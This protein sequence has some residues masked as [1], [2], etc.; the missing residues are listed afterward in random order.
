[1]TS[2]RDRKPAPSV[3]GDRAFENAC[4]GTIS[5]GFTRIVAASD[6]N[7]GASAH[8]AANNETPNTQA[9]IFSIEARD[10]TETPREATITSQHQKVPSASRDEAISAQDSNITQPKNTTPSPKAQSLAKGSE[11]KSEKL[12]GTR[13]GEVQPPIGIKEAIEPQMISSLT[14][15]HSSNHTSTEQIK[16]SQA[17][18]QI[19]VVSL[20]GSSHN[21]HQ[22]LSPSANSGQ[23]RS[24]SIKAVALSS[25]ESSNTSVKSQRMPQGHNPQAASQLLPES[26]VAIQDEAL[27]LT[28]TSQNR[29]RPPI[30]TSQ[31]ARQPPRVFD[32]GG[33]Q[34]NEAPAGSTLQRRTPAPFGTSSATARVPSGITKRV[35]SSTVTPGNGNT[36]PPRALPPRTQP[37]VPSVSKAPTNQLHL[38]ATPQKR[39][40]PSS[41]LPVSQ[42]GSSPGV[43]RRSSAVTAIDA[44][45]ADV[46]DSRWKLL[47]PFTGGFTSPHKRLPDLASNW[48]LLPPFAPPIDSQ[49]PLAATYRSSVRSIGTQTVS[50][51]STSTQTT[52]TLNI[53]VNPGLIANT[54]GNPARRP[55]PTNTAGPRGPAT[56]G[57]NIARPPASASPAQN[58]SQSLAP[59][60]VPAK[61]PITGA[62]GNANATGVASRSP[63]PAPPGGSAPMRVPI[64]KAG[65]GPAL[66]AADKKIRPVSA[67][68]PEPTIIAPKPI[69][70]RVASVGQSL[71]VPEQGARRA[72]IGSIPARKPS[73]ALPPEIAALVKPPTQTTTP[74]TN[75]PAATPS[76]PRTPAPPMPDTFKKMPTRKPPPPVAAAS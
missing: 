32:A 18:T 61:K 48:K 34:N 20:A 10:A 29:P 55:P 30:N 12:S 41:P 23:K 43:S 11:N 21:E 47:P 40:N 16:L 65:T 39:Q 57:S 76:R 13:Q 38:D 66:S 42:N 27:P 58:P 63:F 67:T 9:S 26:S 74:T 7:A 5:G 72:S 6:P 22:S 24:L 1:M 54:A 46:E 17:T 35:E 49:V 68:G 8:V 53:S 60:N 73:P 45:S 69:A 28:T 71:G 52:G 3:L 56:P 51:A 2:S 64:K 62:G 70:P 36:P 19:E 31:D 33:T 14:R 4:L 15:T 59:S 75:G 25:P 37:S 44:H 50:T